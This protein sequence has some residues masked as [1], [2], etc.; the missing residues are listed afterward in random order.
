MSQL[1]I[2]QAAVATESSNEGPAVLR[3]GL[4]FFPCADCGARVDIALVTKTGPAR[5][6]RH[7]R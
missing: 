7:G 3:P 6:D 4:V 5:C 1:M 2:E